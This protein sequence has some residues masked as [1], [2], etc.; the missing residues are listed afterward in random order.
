L[1]Y[2]FHFHLD[3]GY[4]LSIQGVLGGIVLLVIAL[5]LWFRSLWDTTLAGNYV[6]GMVG[7]ITMGFVTWVMLANFEPAG[8][9]GTNRLT[10][11][12]IVPLIVGTIT[13]LLM[14]RTLHL[15]I[16]LLGGLG[17]LALGLW[18]LGW[19]TNLS[20]TSSYGRAI[21]LTV[22]VVVFMLLAPA[23]PHI[24]K[25]GTALSASYILFMGLDIFF[26]T[27]FLY[28]FTATMDN[29]SNHGIIYIF[30]NEKKN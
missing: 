3:D 25:L 23:H 13:S 1:I 21:L 4:R 16:M 30:G 5:L 26:H 19:K 9:Y 10:I 22:L 11:Y 12:F 20:V 15:Y 29:N 2:A 8:T 14:A 24:H 6:Q 7:F 17:G 27:G 18:V 28:I